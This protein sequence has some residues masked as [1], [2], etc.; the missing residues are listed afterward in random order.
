M[1]NLFQRRVVS[2]NVRLRMIIRNPG[3]GKVECPV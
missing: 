2:M 1:S 3:G